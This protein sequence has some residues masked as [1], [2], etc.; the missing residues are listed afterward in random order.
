MDGLGAAGRVGGSKDAGGVAFPQER[1]AGGGGGVGEM[2]A[3]LAG[4]N[5]TSSSAKTE[6]G[7]RGATE[8]G[9][10]N[11]AADDGALGTAGAGAGIAGPP[12]G[13]GEAAATAAYAGEEGMARNGGAGCCD[14]AVGGRDAYRWGEGGWCVVAG[15]WANDC[16]Q[17]GRLVAALA[18]GDGAGADCAP[19]W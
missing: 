1:G 12:V 18:V 13:P 9:G 19:S 3:I 11:G 17:F 16:A 15:C 14:W 4:T 2:G 7:L 5:C 8:L 6:R 10:T